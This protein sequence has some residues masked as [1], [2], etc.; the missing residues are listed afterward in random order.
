MAFKPGEELELGPAQKYKVVTATADLGP[1]TPMPFSTATIFELA[2]EAC[3]VG[4]AGNGC[5]VRLLEGT[6]VDVCEYIRDKRDLRIIG[7]GWGKTIFKPYAQTGVCHG[8]LTRGGDPF[9]G[10]AAPMLQ[11]AGM[12]NFEIAYIEAD[13]D[14]ETAFYPVPAV[15]TPDGSR[16]ELSRCVHPL[17]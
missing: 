2:V 4:A 1:A 7:K 10:P 8:D 12:D 9:E 3:G 11:F 17:R 5:E 15:S 6:Y 16:T 13:G 14:K